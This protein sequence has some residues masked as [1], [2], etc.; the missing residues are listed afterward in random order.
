MYWHLRLDSQPFW[1]SHSLFCLR[2]VEG[3]LHQWARNSRG[4]AAR[5]LAYQHSRS[6]AQYHGH[7]VDVADRNYDKGDEVAR[8]ETTLAFDEALATAKANN[9]RQTVH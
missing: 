8:A 6:L 4:S 3:G 5:S 7:S 9:S 1:H 2:T